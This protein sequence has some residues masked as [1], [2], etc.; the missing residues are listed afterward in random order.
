MAALVP[1]SRA[2]V[3]YVG[4]MW[5]EQLILAW[6]DVAEYVICTPD[7]DIYIEQLDAN[8]VDL[9]GLR[10]CPEGGGLPYGLST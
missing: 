4:D 2:Y 5:H 8:N 1:G 3:H 9:E 10:F 7:G 6:I